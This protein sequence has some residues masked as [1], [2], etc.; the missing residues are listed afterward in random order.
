MG[1]EILVQTGDVF[2]LGDHQSTRLCV[3]WLDSFIKKHQPSTLLDYGS[4]T[5]VLSILASIRGVPSV[6]GVE[7]DP[8][9]VQQAKENAAINLQSGSCR[10]VLPEDEDTT[11]QYDVVVANILPHI[12]IGLVSTLSS[13]TRQGQ[14]IA[15]SGIRK[16]EEDAVLES[17]SPYF[18]IS[19]V[20]SDIGFVLLVGVKKSQLVRNNIRLKS[21]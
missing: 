18:D 20:D 1:T 8:L 5:G 17:F 14:M 9:G 7:I 19:V 4:G 11:A 21:E 15:L 10:F 12:L 2:G 3:K 16:S 6:L 13:R